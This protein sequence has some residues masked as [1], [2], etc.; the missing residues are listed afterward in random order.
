VANHLLGRLFVY[1]GICL[2][3]TFRKRHAVYHFC[4]YW[5]HVGRGQCLD[6][7]GTNQ[8]TWA[9]RPR[10]YNPAADGDAFLI[11]RTSSEIERLRGVVAQLMH[12]AAHDPLTGLPTRRL[13]LERLDEELARD[14]ADGLKIAVLFVDLDNLNW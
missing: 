11:A 9:Q 3:A 10:S 6:C 5:L 1:P 8:R 13:L 2:P 4:Y 12:T 14:A 7:G